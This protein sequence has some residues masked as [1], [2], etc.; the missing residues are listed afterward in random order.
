MAID[1]TLAEELTY[2]ERL[3]WKKRFLSL[4]LEPISETRLVAVRRRDNGLE[5]VL[6]NEISREERIVT[7]DQ[8]I[9]EQ[10][11]IP[12]NELFEELRPASSNYGVTDI[13]TFVRAEPQPAAARRGF[14]LHRIGDAVSSRNIHAAMLD[15]V[16]ICSP[17]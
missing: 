16:R 11:S 7:V 15:A 8:V 6:L 2:A 14:E 13:E 5:A 12:M 9:V 17:L 3:R 4:G 1:A 10:G